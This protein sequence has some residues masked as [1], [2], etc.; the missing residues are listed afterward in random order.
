MLDLVGKGRTEPFIASFAADRFYRFSFFQPLA[1]YHL[2]VV[3][4]FC[5]SKG[6]DG[7]M[8][9][10]LE[11]ASN[12]SSCLDVVGIHEQARVARRFVVNLNGKLWNGNGAC[13]YATADCGGVRSEGE[14]AAG[15]EFCLM[16]GIHF[17]FT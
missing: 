9:S 5:D 16:L 15:R 2:L 7:H 4:C 13:H 10:P 17:A 1:G 14:Q 6:M 8:V 12:V 11:M 3:C